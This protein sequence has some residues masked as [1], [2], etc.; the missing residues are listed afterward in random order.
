VGPALQWV[1]PH[2]RPGHG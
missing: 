1:S 2:L